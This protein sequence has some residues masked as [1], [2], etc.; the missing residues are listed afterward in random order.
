[1]PKLWRYS[2]TVVCLLILAV[3]LWQPDRADEQNP[4]SSQSKPSE[5]Y[6]DAIMEDAFTQQFNQQGDIEYTLS[7]KQIRYFDDT[8][9]DTGIVEYDQPKLIFFGDVES[10]TIVLSAQSGISDDDGETIELSDNVQIIQEA[11]NDQ[12]NQLTTESLTIFPAKKLAETDKP[13]MITEPNGTTTATG[14]KADFNKQSFELL[15]NVRG[16]YAP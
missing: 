10:A 4:L 12:Q 2:L 5:R 7:S 9:N 13:V 3:L 14:L 1:M 16:N 8:E 15:S 6:P 11:E